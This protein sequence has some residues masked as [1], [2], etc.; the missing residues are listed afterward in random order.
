MLA[1]ASAAAC[2]PAI[3]GMLQI[4]PLRIELAAARPVAALTVRNGDAHEMSVQAEVLEWT[5]ENGRDVY[6]PTRDVLV[7]PVIFKLAPDGTQIVRLGLQV[8]AGETERAYRL[9]VQQ[10]P[11]QQPHEAGAGVHM[12]TLLRLGV[13]V[14]VPSTSPRIAARWQVLATGSGSEPALTLENT[15]STHI[16]LTRVTVRAVGGA[17]DPSFGMSLYVLPQQT[18]RVPVRWPAAAGSAVS[19]SAVADTPTPLPT[20]QL[21]VPRA[22]AAAR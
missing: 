15:G 19:V 14:F 20:V 7:N 11:R 4:A 9:F 16:Q 8:T 1:I 18:A 12:Q 13:P 6:R 21:T 10:L 2:T 17:E 3:A 5:Q 22:E